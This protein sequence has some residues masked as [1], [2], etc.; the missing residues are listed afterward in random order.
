[1]EI[2]LN[3]DH[4]KKDYNELRTL[5]IKL[6]GKSASLTDENIVLHNLVEELRETVDNPGKIPQKLV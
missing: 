1:M 5:Y 4:A 3:L 6:L 2:D